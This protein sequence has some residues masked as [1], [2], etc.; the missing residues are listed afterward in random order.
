MDI[1][2]QGLTA[3]VALAAVA[4]LGYLV[5][6]RRRQADGERVAGEELAAASQVIHDLERISQEMRESLAVHQGNVARFWQSINPTHSPG[7]EVAAET[8]SWQAAAAS[9]RQPTL[10]M[11]HQI[12]RA[13]DEIRRHTGTLSRI[14]QQVPQR[15]RR[16]DSLRA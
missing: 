7:A 12:A 10:R 11:S 2:V 9:M 1:W 16:A 3:P 13:Y 15:T 8:E 4:G 5:G 6:R 14:K